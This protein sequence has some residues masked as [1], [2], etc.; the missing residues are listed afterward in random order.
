MDSRFLRGNIGPYSGGKADGTILKSRED[1]KFGKYG[2]QLLPTCRVTHRALYLRL[3]KF[4]IPVQPRRAIYL[5]RFRELRDA[6]YPI[7]PSKLIAGT[8]GRF[9]EL[10]GDWFRMRR[11]SGGMEAWH[12]FRLDDNRQTVIYSASRE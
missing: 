4:P 12:L 7:S 6:T 10:I 2:S 3:G 1:R 9:P 11:D 5:S 8:L